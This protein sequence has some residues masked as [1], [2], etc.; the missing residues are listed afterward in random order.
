MTMSAL[1]AALRSEPR[2]DTT[3][4]AL[5]D[6]YAEN[7][8]DDPSGWLEQQC[9]S[10]SPPISL[11]FFGYGYGY[12]DGDGYG[13]GDGDGSGSGSGSG[14]GDGYGSGSGDGSGSGSG[15]GYGDGYGYGYGD[16]DGYG[17]GDGQF[18]LG[19]RVMP[20]VGGNWLMI[21]PHGWVLCGRVAEQTGPYQF[22]VED[23]VVVC[24]TGGVPWDELADGKRREAATY[25]K[26]NTV[27]I[28]PQ[29]VISRPWVGDLPQV[30]S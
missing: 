12:G 22:R 28:G 17:Y 15:S 9:R 11:V 6:W 16:G 13:Y 21:L 25:R 23:A 30:K 14:Y 8:D 1:L 26:W 24:R 19:E 4:L 18:T 27:N 5:A 29:F 7:R 10:G 2:D 3:R 20:E